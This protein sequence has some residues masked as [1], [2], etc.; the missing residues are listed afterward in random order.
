[1]ALFGAIEGP[2]DF[3]ARWLALQK[4]IDRTVELP[5]G[6]K[7]VVDPGLPDNVVEFRDRQGRIVGKIVNVDLSAPKK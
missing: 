3:A 5:G 1:M 6:F 2:E 4:E 7:A